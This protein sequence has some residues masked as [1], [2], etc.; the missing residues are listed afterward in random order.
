MRKKLTRPQIEEIVR[1]KLKDKLNE[2]SYP[3]G[4]HIPGT[5]QTSAELKAMSPEAY[6][7]LKD[8]NPWAGLDPRPAPAPAAPVAKP[9]P[10]AV[11]VAKPAPSA[12]PVGGSPGLAAAPPVNQYGGDDAA[13]NIYDYFGVSPPATPSRGPTPPAYKGEEG[14]PM[15]PPPGNRDVPAMP[16]LREEENMDEGVGMYL[17]NKAGAVSD[18]D[19]KNYNK[20]QNM[21]KQDKKN[22]GTSADD[23]KQGTGRTRQFSQI[24][25]GG[26]TE[27]QLR[28]FVRSKLTQILKAPNQKKVSESIFAPNHYCV[29][30]GG[31]YLNG[32]VHMAEAVSHN[33]NEKLGKVTHYN[34]RLSNG[35][36]LENVPAEAIQITNASLAEDHDGHPA[37]R[38]EESEDKAAKKAMK[39]E[40]SGDRNDKDREQ[41]HGKQRQKAGSDGK[42]GD[43]E[44]Q[45]PTAAV[46]STTGPAPAESLAGAAASAESQRRLAQNVANK[47]K[48]RSSRAASLDIT[49]GSVQDAIK[50]TGIYKK[51]A[52]YKE[53]VYTKGKAP[54]PVDAATRRGVEHRSS[55]AFG[56]LDSAL[57]EVSDKEWY[58]SQLFE[59]LSRK[60][61]K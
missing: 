45:A 58:D 13:G 3:D 38:D 9:T 11:P 57:E 26:T 51:P 42:K 27:S 44:E 7:D 23:I 21:K 32:K 14:Q 20:Y 34:M 31:V 40:G 43:L 16:P 22:L 52:G 4:T 35:R 28:E 39:T 24:D 59:A 37:K 1:A 55:H 50:G 61:S 6:A 56:D 48:A 46:T 54:E 10:A 18:S 47:A 19:Y 60:W 30:H 25:S 41:G 15:T 49:G 5:R 17:M 12:T 53:P 29:H 36:I 33:Y 8:R 2:D